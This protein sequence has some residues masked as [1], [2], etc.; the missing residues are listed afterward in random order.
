LEKKHENLKDGVVSLK[1]LQKISAR[2][3][4]TKAKTQVME[5]TKDLNNSAYHNDICYKDMFNVRYMGLRLVPSKTAGNELISHGFMIDDCRE[6]MEKGYS[7]RKRA[8][9]TVE[10]WLDFGNKTCNVVVVKD[11]NELMREEVWV[12]IHFGR[13][14]KK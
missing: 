10:K 13:F 5:K 8:R 4:K 6:I 1:V 14:T 12:I 2:G 9:G 3:I 11:Y 7:P